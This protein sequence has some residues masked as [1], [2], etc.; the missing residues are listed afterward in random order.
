MV[1]LTCSS[2]RKAGNSNFY[3]EK[4]ALL[5]NVI[6]TETLPYAMQEPIFTSSLLSFVLPSFRWVEKLGCVESKNARNLLMAALLLPSSPPALAS[7]KK[8]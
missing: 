4:M 7:S 2:V 1:M 3:T 6:D 5:N 8:E